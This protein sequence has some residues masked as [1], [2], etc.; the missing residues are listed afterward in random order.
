MADAQTPALYQAARS[1]TP[2]SV[3]FQLG[4]QITQLFGAQMPAMVP[5]VS[6]FDDSDTRLQWKFQ[7]AG[8][9]GRWTTSCMSHSD[10]LRYESSVWFDS[11]TRAGVRFGIARV[12]FGRRIELA[13]RIRETGRRIEFLEAGGDVREKLEAAV[14]KAETIGCISNGGWR[15]LRGWRSTAS[16]DA[17][18]LI[19]K[20]PAELAAEILARISGECGLSETKEKTNRRIPFSKGRESSRNGAGWKCEQC[21]RQ[22]LE[23][24]RRCG[25]LAEEK[26]GSSRAVWAR[27]RVATEECPKSLVT[28]ASMEASKNFTR[29][30]PRA[31]A[32]VT[33]T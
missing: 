16:G 10:K 28:P 4:E 22:R 23:A 6:E 30:R 20:G 21:R 18:L 15:R 27:G 1:R 8:R 26:A 12:S 13:R 29:G 31:E 17:E 11:E 19:E 24:R 33:T 9:R 32:L 5:E 14:L 7:K 3:M 2:I 25:F